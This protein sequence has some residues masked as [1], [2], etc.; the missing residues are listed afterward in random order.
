MKIIDAQVHIWSQTVTP[1]S[2]LH[3]KVEKFTAEEV[4][5]EMDEAG[6]DAA[7][8]HPPAGWDP[9]SNALAI[10]AARTYPDRFAIMGNFPLEDPDNRKLVH[11]WRAQ[12]GMMGLRW[13]LLLE[14]HQKW[15]YDGSLDWLWPAAEQEGLPLAM[16]GGLFLPKFR[17]IAECHPGLKMILDHCGLNRHGRDAEAFVHLD[18]LVALAQ[19]PNVAVKATGAPHYST[20]PYPFRNIHDGLHR[21][22]DAYGPKRMFWGTDITRMPCSYRQCV[23]FFT[24]ELPWLKG[25]DLDDVMGRALCAWIGWDYASVR[26]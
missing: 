14:A 19:L 21:I 3:R 7:L 26:G 16:M 25:A 5:A 13:P 4:L 6:V 18:E 8:I 10:E 17:E 15:L 9:D 20:E 24:E 23:T 2:G 22:F 1:T 11:G 12:P